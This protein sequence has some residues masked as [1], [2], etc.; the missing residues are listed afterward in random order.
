M[1]RGSCT[2]A[3]A[4]VWA[5]SVA[6]AGRRGGVGAVA[7]RQYEQL[8]RPHVEGIL[9]RAKRAQGSKRTVSWVEEYVMYGFMWVMGESSS[10]VF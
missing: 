1:S 9:Q 2:S 6:G 3:A 8:R 10:A 7:A 5:G 4:F